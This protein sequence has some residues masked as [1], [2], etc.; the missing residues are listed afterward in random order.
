MTNVKD[1]EA[2]L[3]ALR[4]NGDLDYIYANMPYAHKVLKE[5]LDVRFS[6]IPT[7][8]DTQKNEL[9]NACPEAFPQFKPNETSSLKTMK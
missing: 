4:K 6:K 7:D 8:F 9:Y 2:A 1:H 3:E 5:Y